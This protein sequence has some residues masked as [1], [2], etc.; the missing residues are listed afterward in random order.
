[1]IN[2]ALSHELEQRIARLESGSN[3][4]N[5]VGLVEKAAYQA[6]LGLINHVPDYTSRFEWVPDTLISVPAYCRDT[7]PEIIEYGCYIDEYRRNALS[8]VKLVWNEHLRESWT[9]NLRLLLACEQTVVEM[10]LLICPVSVTTVENTAQALGINSSDLSAAFNKVKYWKASEHIRW[11]SWSDPEHDILTWIQRNPELKDHI[12]TT[13]HFTHEGHHPPIDYFSNYMGWPVSN[14]LTEGFCEMWAGEPGVIKEHAVQ[15]AT[16]FGGVGGVNFDNL[17]AG[18]NGVS[19][20]E[21]IK[22]PS[23]TLGWAILIGASAASS[24][25]G[26]PDKGSGAL[27]SGLQKY[28]GLDLNQAFRIASENGLFTQEKFNDLLQKRI[29]AALSF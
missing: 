29:N 10:P 21:S 1:M 5:A 20:L 28:R 23:Y 12:A 26:N 2:P 17:L 18:L 24:S 8:E 22:Y 3:R 15:L 19:S 14:W 27:L 11:R 9:E 6:I 7:S 16:Q 4:S 13:H 25:Q